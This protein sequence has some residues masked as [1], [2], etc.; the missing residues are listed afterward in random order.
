MIY[1]CNLNHKLSW[2]ELGEP[3]GIAEGLAIHFSILC[4]VKVFISSVQQQGNTSFSQKEEKM[5]RKKRIV[6]DL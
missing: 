5:K 6:P 2:Q 1:R 4:A 3:R